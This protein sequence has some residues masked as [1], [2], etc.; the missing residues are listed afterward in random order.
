M[1]LTYTQQPQKQ[2]IKDRKKREGNNST[3]RERA[4][5]GTLT[6]F[7]VLFQLMLTYRMPMMV[8]ES[9]V[10]YHWMDC[11]VYY[12]CPRCHSLLEREFLAYCSQC[13]Q[14]LNWRHYRKT[15]QIYHPS[16]KRSA[17]K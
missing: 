16:F 10:L 6:D 4:L 1:P 3:V 17:R 14:C 9:L 7:S 2:T 12:Y 13:G 15:K 8:S 5:P 11:T